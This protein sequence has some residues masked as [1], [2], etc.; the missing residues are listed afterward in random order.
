MINFDLFMIYF[1]IKFNHNLIIILII[2][3][4]NKTEKL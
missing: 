1:M 4:I 3:L 2:I